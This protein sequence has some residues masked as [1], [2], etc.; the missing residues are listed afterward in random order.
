MSPRWR[1]PS[2]T[3]APSPTHSCWLREWSMRAQV[4]QTLV[5]RQLGELVQPG[6][7]G[8]R[9]LR[10]RRQERR[11]PL[12]GERQEEAACAQLVHCFGSGS[13]CLSLD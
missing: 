3:T 11:D 4:A 10:L 5:L 13:D 6:A 2:A 12:C 1:T 7:T 9:L 8:A